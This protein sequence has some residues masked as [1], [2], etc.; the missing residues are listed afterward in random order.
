MCVVEKIEVDESG[1]CV[2]DNRMWGGVMYPGPV[3]EGMGPYVCAEEILNVNC[4][5]NVGEDDLD[6]SFGGILP[7]LIWRGAFVSAFIG[8]PRRKG[9]LC[10]TGRWC[11]SRS[12]GH[13]V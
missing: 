2:L 1:E 4:C 7:L 11:N 3:G 8:V 12:V 10:G 9:L 5:G 6:V 13:V